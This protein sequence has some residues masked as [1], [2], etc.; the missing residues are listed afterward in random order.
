MSLAHTFLSMSYL[1]SQAFKKVMGRWLGVRSKSLRVLLYHDI[2]RIDEHNFAEQIQW[3]GDRFQF[4]T[5]NE[6]RNF[7]RGIKEPE[8]DSLLITF[9]DGNISNRRVS[10]NILDPLGIKALFFIVTDFVDLASITKP[11]GRRTKKLSVRTGSDNFSS[12]A[13][14]SWSDLTFLLKKGHTIGAHTRTHPR[15]AHLSKAESFE[16]IVGSGDRLERKL[17]VCIEDFA[18][19]FGDLKSLDSESLNTARCRYEF[20][21]TGLRGDNSCK[22]SPLS[23]RRDSIK[24][25]DSLALIGSFLSGSADILYWKSL[26]KYESWL[27]NPP[28]FSGDWK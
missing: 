24:P 16:E 26:K 7:V 22:V 15:L 17:N 19:T 11:H 13:Y 12:S 23:I 2:K 28:H 9:D 21:Y 27:G 10:E 1:P 4:A 20:I 8:K 18:Y 5:P 14:M 6:F 3:L 25:T